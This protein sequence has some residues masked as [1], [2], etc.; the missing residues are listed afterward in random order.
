MFGSHRGNR[1]MTRDPINIGINPSQPSQP[2]YSMT[3]SR[4]SGDIGEAAAFQV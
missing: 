3:I 1:A 2:S 4:G